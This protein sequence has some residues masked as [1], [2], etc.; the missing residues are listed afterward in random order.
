MLQKLRIIMNF[1]KKENMAKIETPSKVVISGNIS[2]T[3]RDSLNSIGIWADRER[4]IRSVWEEYNKKT[5]ERIFNVNKDS[6]TDPDSVSY[7]ERL[8]INWLK[9]FLFFPTLGSLKPIDVEAFYK[10]IEE[11][12]NYNVSFVLEHYPEL[13]FVFD[14]H[15]KYDIGGLW[16]W[17]WILDQSL[18]DFAPYNDK[19]HELLEKRFNL[20]RFLFMQER[21]Y[22]NALQEVRNGKKKTHWMWYIFPQ[23]KGLGKSEM[24]Q[25]YGIRGQR[26]AWAYISH[27]VL[28]DRLIEITQAVIDSGK[29]P[30]EIFG[31]DTIKFRSCMILFATVCEYNYIDI[32]IFKQA[33]SKYCWIM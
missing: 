14:I 11:P 28:R 12:Y 26:E 29:S 1:A 10:E 33:C 32:P 8:Y 31:N 20:M 22:Q 16:D 9:V 27:K 13:H 25:R 24:S 7:E 23:M 3:D 30:Y 18:C 2:E 5:L 15:H 17:D 19:A 6:N 4:L 21:D